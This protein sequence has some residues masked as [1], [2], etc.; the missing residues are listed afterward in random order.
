MK[1]LHILKTEPDSDTRT[2]IDI[3]SEGD[4]ATF[5]LYKGEPDYG[6][7]IDLIFE[8]DRAISWW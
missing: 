1:T 3:L 8:N 7:L 2:L 5:P 4:A 6:K